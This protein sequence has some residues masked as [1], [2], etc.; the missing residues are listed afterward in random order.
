MNQSQ[1]IVT[2]AMDP[3]FTDNKDGSQRVF[4]QTMVN[5]GRT[6][7]NGEQISYPLSFKGFIPA[8]RVAEGKQSVYGCMFKGDKV[9][10]QG[11]PRTDSYEKDGKK[12]YE[13][14]IYVQKVTL[15]TSKEAS[16]A[17]RA[18]RTETE[19][20]VVAEAPAKAKKATKAK[21]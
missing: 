1:S 17:R 7:K 12:V 3:I 21:A 16:E 20:E 8:E 13:N 11:E 2:L 14:N 19:V 15:L 10:I 4:L 6:D 18:A 5:T 9:L